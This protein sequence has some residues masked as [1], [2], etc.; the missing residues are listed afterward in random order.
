MFC[1]FRFVAFE[2]SDFETWCYKIM[3]KRETLINEEVFWKA[4]KKKS[5]LK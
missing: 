4:G 3:L 2:F 1:E 5:F